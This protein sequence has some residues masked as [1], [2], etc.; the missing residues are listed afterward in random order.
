MYTI[1]KWLF[2]LKINQFLVGCSNSEP[3][4]GWL[5]N[6]NGASGLVSGFITGFLK[7]LLMD[8]NKIA[9][10]IPVDYTANALISV[11]WDTV[12]R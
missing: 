3:D 7:A 2:R 5:D 4:P 12:N 1:T 6:G 9:D 10:I 8:T 11:M